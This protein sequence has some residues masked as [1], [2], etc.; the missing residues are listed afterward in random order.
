[1]D[2]WLLKKK[3]NAYKDKLLAPQ[4]QATTEDEIDE[5]NIE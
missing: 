3:R 5:Q 1:M 4:K 2:G